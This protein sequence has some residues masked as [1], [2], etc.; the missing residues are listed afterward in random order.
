MKKDY[1]I[2]IGNKKYF[3]HTNS[4]WIGDLDIDIY[5]ENHNPLCDGLTKYVI[6]KLIRG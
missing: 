3:C 1:I 6:E 4:H 2:N 5:D